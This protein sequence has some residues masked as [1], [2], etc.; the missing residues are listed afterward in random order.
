MLIRRTGRLCL[1]DS[2]QASRWLRIMALGSVV[3][4]GVSLVSTLEAQQPGTRQPAAPQPAAPGVI[5]GGADTISVMAVVNGETISR[6]HLAQ[7]CR[8]RYGV[9]ALEAMVNRQLILGE[10]QRL[11]IA[12]TDADIDLEIERMAAKFNLPK[13]RWLQVLEQERQMP[14]DRYRQLV[15]MELS[16]RAIAAK[17]IRIEPAEIERLLEAEVGPQVQVRMISLADKGQA[18][19]VLALARSNPDDFGRLAKEYSKDRNSAAVMGIIPPIRKHVGDPMIEGIVFAM[20]EGEISEVIEVANQFVI[21]KCEKIVP[22][23]E[24]SLEQRKIAEQ[25]IVE[26]LTERKMAEAAD[27]L[28]RELQGRVEIV[29]VFNSPELAQ[30][31]PGVAAI[32]DNVQITMRDLSEECIARHGEEVLGG[33][34]HRALLTQRLK[35]RNIQISEQDLQ[36]EIERAAEAEGFAR[37]DGTAD[38]DAWLAKVLETEGATIDLYVRD[39]VW[40]SVALKKLV[41]ES[42]TVDETDLQKG[43]EANY[44][45]RVEILAI[46][47]Q[48]QRVANRVW[49]M[50]TSDPTEANFG[51]LASEYSEEPASKANFGRVPPIA[52]HSGREQMEAE[53]F[54][55]KQGEISGLIN[56]GQ[57]WVILMCTGYT[58]P[59]VTELNAVRGELTAH[60]HEQKLRLAMMAE[61]D[62][63]LAEAQIDNFLTGTS[64]SPKVEQGNR[65]GDLLPVRPRQR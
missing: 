28:L 20:Q 30:R 24:I 37:A 6:E 31:M 44:G 1:S 57:H 5:A 35:T 23:R 22:G 14:L 55:L 63:I 36:D 58:D 7:E 49:Q 62:R 9:E 56:V 45:P 40:P 12:I 4:V 15:W 11:G 27:T 52:R 47:M 32:V 8:A 50:A 42:I 33:E 64:Q 13:E 48:N 19:E 21:V 43:F 54:K 34:I 3:L 25:R 61:F 65:V 60:I 59:V 10:S 39:A 26:Y 18:G 51:R 29:N 38:V 41:S 17:D 2:I 46:V 16:L 53:A